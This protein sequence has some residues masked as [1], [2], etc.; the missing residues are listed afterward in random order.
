MVASKIWRMFRRDQFIFWISS[1]GR[2]LYNLLDHLIQLGCISLGLLY[3]YFHI[4]FCSHYDRRFVFRR[5]SVASHCFLGLVNEVV[6]HLMQ[7]RRLPLIKCFHYI[8]ICHF[9]LIFRTIGFLLSWAE[10]MRLFVWG[11]F[12]KRGVLSYFSWECEWF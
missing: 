8:K 4:R 2:I 10:N 3:I 1:F 5:C 12:A 7:V 9:P 11:F 6:E